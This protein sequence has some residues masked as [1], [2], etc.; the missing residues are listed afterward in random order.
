MHEREGARH[1]QKRSTEILVMVTREG[2]ALLEEEGGV[3]SP[4]NQ[5]QL[6]ILEGR[7]RLSRA[8]RS[9][10]EAVANERG[11]VEHEGVGVVKAAVPTDLAL[12][13]AP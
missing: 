13:A 5:Q 12:R 7:R 9:A 8:R 1:N 6:D 11:L 2:G 10:S 3:A 4:G